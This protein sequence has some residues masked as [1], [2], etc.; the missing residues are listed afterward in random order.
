V[1]VTSFI[2]S[3]IGKCYVWRIGFISVKSRFSV[4]EVVKTVV[5]V[6]NFTVSETI[7]EIQVMLQTFSNM[8]LSYTWMYVDIQIYDRTM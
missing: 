7:A 8:V 5:T 4:L 1:Q 3:K 6:F 2:L